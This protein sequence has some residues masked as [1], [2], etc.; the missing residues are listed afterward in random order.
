[1]TF[2]ISMKRKPGCSIFALHIQFFID[3]LEFE[4]IQENIHPNITK[5]K[6]VLAVQVN[7]KSKKTKNSSLLQGIKHDKIP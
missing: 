5:V 7:L 4:V 3:S 1:M 6:L 2:D